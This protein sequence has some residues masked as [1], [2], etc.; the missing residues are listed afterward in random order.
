[1]SSVVQI[2]VIYSTVARHNEHIVCSLLIQAP[3]NGRGDSYN[4]ISRLLINEYA[5]IAGQSKLEKET[6]WHVSN[7]LYPCK[8]ALCSRRP[9]VRLFG[10]TIEPI[11]DTS[12]HH[13][14]YFIDL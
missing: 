9:F 7:L 10:H 6:R 13:V 8:L 1:M 5:D 2:W 3:I 12:S 11:S 4:P 14:L